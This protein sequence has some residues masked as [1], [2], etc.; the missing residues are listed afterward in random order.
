VRPTVEIVGRR[1]K[2]FTGPFPAFDPWRRALVRA[3]FVRDRPGFRD[4]QTRLVRIEVEHVAHAMA[5]QIDSIDP[6]G[7]FSCQANPHP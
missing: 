3:P 7:E 1:V 5:I 6:L 2:G 4:D